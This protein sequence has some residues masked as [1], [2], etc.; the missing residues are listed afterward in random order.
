MFEENDNKKKDDGSKKP[1]GGF[2][3]PPLTWAVWIAIIGSIAGLMYFYNHKLTQ[4]VTQLT[5]YD[6]FQK[7][8][9]NDIAQAAITINP[10]SYNTVDINGT[11]YKTDATGNFL[12]K[13]GTVVKDPMK[14]EAISFIVPNAQ[15]TDTMRDELLLSPEKSKNIKTVQPNP[16]VSVIGYNLLF[17]V[18]VAALF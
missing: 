6:F 3:F 10:N 14:A 5:Q 2:N 4:N 15:L 12:D 18:A 1:S 9:S 7:F 16:M 8:R 13:S 17:F 11:F